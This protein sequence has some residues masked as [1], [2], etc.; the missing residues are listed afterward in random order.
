VRFAGSLADVLSLIAAA[1]A[2]LFP[3]DDLW[4]KVDLPIVLLEAMVLG[5]PVVALD[6]GPL[7]DLEGAELLPSL[8]CQA[9]L[10]ALARLTSDAAART[11]RVDAQRRTLERCDANAVARAYEALYLELGARGRPSF[12]AK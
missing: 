1:T 7:S 9:W 8:D 12:V 6:A 3:V 10:V 5:V 11:A 4:G 2:V